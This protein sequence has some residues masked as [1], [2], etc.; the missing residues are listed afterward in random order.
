M[1]MSGDYNPP[2]V[3]FDGGP[4]YP[5]AFGITFT[6]MVSGIGLAILGLAG[7]AFAWMNFVE[8]LRVETADLQTKVEEK[9]K[10]LDDQKNI[11]KQLKEAKVKLTQVEQQRQQ[12]YSLFAQKKNMDTVLFDLNQLIDKN[13]VGLRS[14]K[15]AKLQGCPMWVKEQFT[16]YSTGQQ[17]EEQ[18][19]PLVAEAKLRKFQ[20]EVAPAATAPATATTVPDILTDGS[21]GPELNNKLKRQTIN[22]EIEGNFNHAQSIIRRIELLQP[23]LILRNMEVKYGGEQVTKTEPTVIYESDPKNPELPIVV[24]NCQPDTVVTTSFKMDALI[25]LTAEEQ[26]LVATPVASPGATPGASPSPSPSPAA[27]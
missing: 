12:V 13:N 6:P 21:L 17:Y 22:V 11:E 14:A 16:S 26:K 20:P 4:N 1:S 25:P 8:P 19:G 27:K 23:L 3:D 5:S 18:I 2:D 7:A 15:E 9:Q 24:K 10:Q